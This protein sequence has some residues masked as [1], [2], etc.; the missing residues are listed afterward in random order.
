MDAVEGLHEAPSLHISI[1]IKTLS[2]LTTT[3]AL[4][5]CTTKL[6]HSCYILLERNL[7]FLRKEEEK[8][9]SCNLIEGIGEK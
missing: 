1:S 5:I 2:M 7:G 6:L 9:C 4:Q 8:N 3:L